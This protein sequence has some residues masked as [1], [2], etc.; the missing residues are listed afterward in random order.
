MDRKS[1]LIPL[2]WYLYD[3]P[4]GDPLILVNSRT[5]VLHVEYGRRLSQEFQV[6]RIPGSRSPHVPE[7]KP[8]YR[9][10]WGQDTRFF[11][12][13]VD[14]S[15]LVRLSTLSP[16]GSVLVPLETRRSQ[17]CIELNGRLH[18]IY[19]NVSD[20]P[21]LVCGTYLWKHVSRSLSNGDLGQEYLPDTMPT[22]SECLQHKLVW[23]LFTIHPH[24]P[25]REVIKILDKEKEKERKYL[26]LPT[27]YDRLLDDNF[28]EPKPPEPVVTKL[29]AQEAE[30][31]D[32]LV[33]PRDRKRAS[34]IDRNRRFE[35][36]KAQMK[37][38][39]R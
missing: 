37:G 17:V 24:A 7:K 1:Y 35:S 21:K 3:R 19:S 25:K 32:E 39:R 5:P 12:R 30:N 10:S 20:S 28:L 18:G 11:E 16:G 29:P 26:A 14:E 34:A 38:H 33:D 31:D 13:G 36:A 4:Y 9:V 27:S 23:H 22:C 2:G 15:E 6:E 8:R